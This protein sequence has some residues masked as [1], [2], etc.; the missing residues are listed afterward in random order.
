MVSEISCITS[1]FHKIYDHVTDLVTIT[2]FNTKF[3]IVSTPEETR[4]VDFSYDTGAFVLDEL[5]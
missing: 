5:A 3:S 1:P 2:T 4:M